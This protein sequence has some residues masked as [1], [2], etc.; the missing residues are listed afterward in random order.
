MSEC[1]SVRFKGRHAEDPSEASRTAGEQNGVGVATCIAEM[2]APHSPI[3]F[4][5]G[6]HWHSE[7]D[8]KL[9][10]IGRIKKIEGSTVS[11][12]AAGR[13]TAER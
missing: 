13:W 8:L 10:L 3:I 5:A 9:R 6:K 7:P 1:W 2:V 4:R 11:S 12:S